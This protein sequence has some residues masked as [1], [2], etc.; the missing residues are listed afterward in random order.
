MRRLLIATA[1]AVAM[2]PSKGL[3]M[4]LGF[5]IKGG[6]GVGY[7]SMGEFNDNLQAVREEYSLAF[8]DL[9]SGFNVLLDGRIWMF[10]R[11]A[12]SVGYEHFWAEQI[13]PTGS[14]NYVTY[15][16]PADVMS[17][18]GVVH[19]FRVPMVIDIN[20]GAKGTFAKVVY[21][22]DERGR[23]TDYKANDYGWDMF[24]EV[25]TNFLNPVQVG[26]TLGYR[27]LKVDGFEDKYGNSPLFVGNDKPVVIDYSG[28]YFY[29][30]AGVAIW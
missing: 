2:L 19:I 24:T 1:V 16:M 7:Y 30:T 28:V 5:E 11:I 18:G 14:S 21:G 8:D 26:F 10:G 13:M 23:F 3:T 6:I 9:T 20:A 17:L 22:T 12:G 29:F 27:Y 15:E 4:P 25:N